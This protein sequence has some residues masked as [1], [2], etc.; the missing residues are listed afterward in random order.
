M[1]L[2]RYE[3]ESNWVELWEQVCANPI[4]QAVLSPDGRYVAT[5]STGD[6]LV[7]IWQLEDFIQSEDRE[8]NRPRLSYLRHPC[9]VIG[10]QWKSLASPDRNTLMTSSADHLCRLWREDVSFGYTDFYLYAFIDPKEWITPENQDPNADPSEYG[11]PVG[12]LQWIDV[13]HLKKL[14]MQD[15]QDKPYDVQEK[16]FNEFEIICKDVDEIFFYIGQD[17]TVIY[18]GLKNFGHED[19]NFGKHAFRTMT[20]LS[21]LLFVPHCI[22]KSFVPYFHNIASIFP[23]VTPQ[24]QPDQLSFTDIIVVGDRGSSVLDEV[25]P[26]N[27]AFESNF[28]VSVFSLDL[29]HVMPFATQEPEIKQ[30]KVFHG[31]HDYVSG[32][33]SPRVLNSPKC[34]LSLGLSNTLTLWSKT[35]SSLYRDDELE[36]HGTTALDGDIY[37][38][39]VP[40]SWLPTD[41]ENAAFVVSRGKYLQVFMYNYVEPELS[42]LRSFETE[43]HEQLLEVGNLLI[44]SPPGKGIYVLILDISMENGSFWS[45]RDDFLEK[46]RCF[47]SLNNPNSDILSLEFHSKILEFMRGDFVDTI[48]N[49]DADSKPLDSVFISVSSD[50]SVFLC[51]IIE[52]DYFGHAPHQIKW[53]VIGSI[54]LPVKSGFKVKKLCCGGINRF[55]VLTAHKDLKEDEVFL[56]HCEIATQSL[57]FD[58]SITI[59]GKVIDLAWR[60]SR[61]KQH[62]LS[63]LLQ[64]RMDCYAFLPHLDGLSWNHKLILSIPHPKMY[65]LSKPLSLNWLSDGGYVIAFGS[66]LFYG[67]SKLGGKFKKIFGFKG[68][69]LPEISYI[70]HVDFGTLHDIHP[71]VLLQHISLGNFDIVEICL[72]HFY[73]FSKIAEDYIDNEHGLIIP[74]IPPIQLTNPKNSIS[75]NSMEQRKPEDIFGLDG[76]VKSVNNIEQYFDKSHA[77]FMGQFLSERKLPGFSSKEQ[78]V[79]LA[80][81]SSFLHLKSIKRALD[82]NG[83]RF[84]LSLRIKHQ[85]SQSGDG[86]CFL[87]ERDVSFG[88]F[89][90]TQEALIS[91]CNEIWGQ[92][93]LWEEAANL[94]MVHWIRSNDL[95]KKQMEKIAKNQFMYQNLRNPISCALL[96]LALGKKKL[97]I[98]MW[99]TAHENPEKEKM[100]SFLKKAGDFS[101]ER[102]RIAAAK[103]AF[104]LLGKQR[105]KFAAA[106][107][108]LAGNVDDGISVCKKQMNDIQLALVISR[109]SYGDEHPKTLG[110]Y[111]DIILSDA[112]KTQDRWTACRV[113][114]ILKRKDLALKALSCPLSSID[115]SKSM[116][117]DNGPRD[118]VNSVERPV[119]TYVEPFSPVKEE[120]SKRTDPRLFMLYKSLINSFKNQQDAQDVIFVDEKMIFSVISTY[121]QVGCYILV[122]DILKLYLKYLESK[123]N[124]KNF[125]TEFYCRLRA[126]I[127]HSMRKFASNVVDASVVISRNPSCFITQKNFGRFRNYISDW[128]NS[129]KHISGIYDEI[130]SGFRSILALK[131]LN[132]RFIENSENETSSYEYIKRAVK[133]I[134]SEY[135]CEG[136]VKS[137]SI[138]NFSS[139][140]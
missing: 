106:F 88:Y 32:L 85:T 116:Q 101:E 52:H 84:A 48:M 91:E 24:T 4:E 134:A 74:S 128:K 66:S 125:T 80:I 3:N 18:W 67:S 13:Q 38:G 61:S 27:I 115:Y 36:W 26:A 6:C 112:I 29:A 126:I 121:D 75:A 104:A 45:I 65:S 47:K 77:Q 17:G 102:W 7:K 119:N 39:V 57:C 96:Y 9:D 20:K 25:Q 63:V 137:A 78:S 129:I 83:V 64:D 140:A 94:G 118:I 132:G 50:G 124:Q 23:F 62:M 86:S 59:Y 69:V 35:N 42:K 131:E 100:V 138:I 97:W 16:I 136:M 46:S 56:C 103:N 73:N 60:N 117:L 110:L 127:H 89:S 81:C 72:L 10:L 43:K 28:S 5:C 51:K 22:P 87:D 30:I 130:R 93:L 139:I 98:S 21:A 120:I 95:L 135:G 68:S 31:Q 113:L 90:E 122:T 54:S 11:E 14:V 34:V 40:F 79:F 33:F 76:G 70:A 53:Q 114:H 107:F 15:F 105:F 49:F 133:E 58:D 109:L 12:S 92:N 99:K 1:T 2:W 71:E 55:A 111:T 82:E 108:L 37:D 19:G 123:D 41:K 8:N 44:F